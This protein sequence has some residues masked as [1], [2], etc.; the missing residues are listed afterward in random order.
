MPPGSLKIVFFSDRTLMSWD[1]VVN[2]PLWRNWLAR[3]AVNRKAGGSSP[4]RGATTKVDVCLVQFF[5]LYSF[6]GY[7]YL[8]TGGFK[9]HGLYSV[10]ASLRKDTMITISIF[11]LDC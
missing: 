7:F 6:L 1:K 5:Q 8:I 4:P 3:S 2:M 10:W 9:C 11:Q